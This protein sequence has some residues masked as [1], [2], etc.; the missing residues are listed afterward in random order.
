MTDL[1]E[2]WRTAAPGVRARADDVTAVGVDACAGRPGRATRTE[3]MAFHEAGHI[4][5]AWSRE[6]EAL[7]P[8]FESLGPL[9]DPWR[10]IRFDG[11]ASAR[12]RE[13]AESAIIVLT[14]TQGSRLHV[15]M[16]MQAA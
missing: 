11:D 12:A 1:A 2:G 3:W 14:Y 6:F 8:E 16:S 15:L 4:V 10:G 5:A 13:Q 7:T 9:A